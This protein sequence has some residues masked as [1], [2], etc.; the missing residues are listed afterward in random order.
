[1]SVEIEYEVRYVTALGNQRV[2]K[3][4]GANEL[5]ARHIFIEYFAGRGYQI[6]SIEEKDQDS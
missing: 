4:A 6:V 3:V 1:M 2:Q 5:H